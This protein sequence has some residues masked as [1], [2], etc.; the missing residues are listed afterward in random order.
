MGPSDSSGVV[1][2]GRGSLG[3]TVQI[4]YPLVN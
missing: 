3:L 1:W 2:A 4:F